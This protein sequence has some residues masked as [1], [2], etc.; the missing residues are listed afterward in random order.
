MNKPLQKRSQATRAKLTDAAQKAVLSKGF[1]SMRV[2]DVV[3]E[4]GVAKGTF[5]A[6]FQDKEV[7]MDLLIGREIETFLDAFEELPPPDSL[8]ELVNRLIP[9]MNFMTSER[10]VFDVIL[11]HSGAAAKEEIGPIALTF[12]HQLV[13]FTRWLTEKPFRKD[14]SPLILAEGI[15]AFTVQCMGLQFCAINR[16]EPMQDRLMQYL[17]AWLIAPSNPVSVIGAQKG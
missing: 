4:A 5:F 12:E 8:D 13:V 1:A 15:Q 3:Q 16:E 11:R 6:H 17:T 7:L 2:E 10:Y 14:V 9:L